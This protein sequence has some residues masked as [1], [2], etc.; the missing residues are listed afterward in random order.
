MTGARLIL[1]WYVRCAR[2][3]IQRF[4]WRR[5]KRHLVALSPPCQITASVIRPIVPKEIHT[6]ICPCCGE[7][8]SVYHDR[9]G[10]VWKM[11]CYGCNQQWDEPV[12]YLDEVRA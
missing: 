11:S 2:I 6:T 12:Q 7:H 9:K 8:R 5:K 1:R 3:L 4:F 10:D